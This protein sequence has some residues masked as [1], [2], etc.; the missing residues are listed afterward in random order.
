M[1]SPCSRPCVEQH[2]HHLRHAAGRGAGRPRRS[3]PEGL[4]SQSTG[5]CARIALE[6]VER[7][8]HAGRVG[9]RQA[10]AAPRWSSRRVAMITRDRVLERLAG[11]DVARLEVRLD[12][13]DQHPRRLAR[14]CPPSRRPRLAMV[15]RVRAGSC[16]APR[17]TRTWCWRCTCRR[18]SPRRGRRCRSIRRQLLVVDLAGAELARPPRTTLTMVRSWPFA[19]AG[20]DG[21]AVDEDRRARSAAPCAITPPGMFL[22]QPPTA[23]TPSMLWPPHAVSIAVGDDLARDE[24]VLHALGAHRDAVADRDGAED[25]RHRAAGPRRPP[26]PARRGSRPALQGV[27]VL[28]AVGDADDRLV[29]VVVVEADGAE[30]GAVGRALRRPR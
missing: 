8:R 26:R 17:T 16:P 3:W 20:H 1:Q 7:P 11:D 15:R 29:E 10:G 24:R 13:L 18:T 6:V 14:R 12:R 30:H 22:S 28:V 21:A 9:D 23:S 25:L 2:L 5:T 4:R 19:V 27:I